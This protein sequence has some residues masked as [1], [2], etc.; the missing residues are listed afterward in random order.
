MLLVRVVSCWQV[1]P[2]IYVLPKTGLHVVKCVYIS[3]ATRRW[4]V[5]FGFY[6]GFT[7]IPA[8]IW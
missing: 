7:I 8:G 1:T 5:W 2:Y 6:T 4:W 3:P